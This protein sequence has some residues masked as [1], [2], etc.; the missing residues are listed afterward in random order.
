MPTIPD[1]RSLPGSETACELGASLS[2]IY[3][4][5][6]PQP[7]SPASA[8]ML[9]TRLA[10]SYC[11][12]SA[13]STQ[14]RKPLPQGGDVSQRLSRSLAV[15]QGGR[16]YPPLPLSGCLR[17]TNLGSLLYSTCSSVQWDQ[18]PVRR[19]QE[20]PHRGRKVNP[21]LGA[22]KLSLSWRLSWLM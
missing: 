14:R 3:R 2:L 17:S 12:I 7:H 16:K 22:M 18:H 10:G 6:K 11:L 9:Q 21:S 8:D 4:K 5:I 1:P 13:S 19:L 15:T 20:K